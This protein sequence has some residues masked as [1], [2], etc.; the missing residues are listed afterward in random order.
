[1]NGV[2]FVYI[3]YEVYFE[4]FIKKFE[5]Q[6]SKDQIRM[7]YNEKLPP[8]WIR[9]K[10]KT[11][12]DKE[13]FFNPKLN[14]SLWKLED[15]KKF[16][17]M[18]LKTSP[19]KKASPKKVPLTTGLSSISQVI[20]KNVARDRMAK[21]QNSLKNSLSQEAKRGAQ[22]N[23]QLSIPKESRFSLSNNSKE[24]PDSRN[25]DKKN[26][27]VQRLQK[28]KANL[29]EEVKL[30]NRNVNKS[31]SLPALITA[32]PEVSSTSVKTKVPLK[33]IQKPKLIL[34]QE[35]VNTDVDMLDLSHQEITR[36][37]PQQS[38]PE[39]Y[40]S[41]E[42]E[43]V[44]EQEVISKVQEIRKCENNNRSSSL[45]STQAEK[46]SGQVQTFNKTE[47]Y[48]IV[49]TNVLLSNIDFIKDI[50]GKYFHRK[51]N[52]I[53]FSK[54]KSNSL[55]IFTDIGKATIYLPYIVLSELDKIK[56]YNDKLAVHAR[57][58]IALIDECFVK[59]D[60]F[61]IGQSGKESFQK[62]IIP[63]DSGDDEILNCCLH[64]LEESEKLIL[65]TNDRNLRNKAFV[66]KIEAYSRDTLNFLD[67]NI[68]NEIKFEIN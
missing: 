55:F 24:P 66:N 64:I 59:K 1:M 19:I 3:F 8:G 33:I 12:P 63:I 40:E 45:V 9:V 25:V 38:M 51:P 6:C 17:E 2:S 43:D 7:N 60:R 29:I 34:N 13:Y 10:S 32:K 18:G 54:F 46:S 26:I 5:I 61:M 20:K 31:A 42:W 58:A 14:K 30:S 48:I 16:D 62:Q 56:S 22:N 50:K 11:R 47:F 41:M 15:L 68:K 53:F 21:L 65:L 28:L 39:P 57:R 52:I 36:E 67:F 4:N 35:S 23:V 27:A 37:S 49:D 44:P